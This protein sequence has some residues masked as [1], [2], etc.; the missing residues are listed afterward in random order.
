MS[1]DEF[2]K[3]MENAFERSIM[4]NNGIKKP[5]EDI[6]LYHG[7]RGGIDGDIAPISRVRCD[8]GKGFYLGTNEMQAKGL[9]CDDSAPFYYS[10][11]LHLSEIDPQKVLRLDGEDWLYTV[12]AHRKNCEEFNGLETAKRY[13]DKLTK[14][15][16]VIGSIA[17]DR[18]NE[19][20]TAFGNRSLTDVGLEAC[21]KYID[22]GEQYVLKTE[23]ACGL[24]EILS[25]KRLQGQELTHAQNISRQARAKSVDVVKEAVD[26]YQRQGRYLNELIKELSSKEIKKNAR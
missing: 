18:M 19:A 20:I 8:F 14:Y 23:S 16:V 10:I 7:S 9:V 24:A 6:V 22:Y 5:L 26:K 1:S 21:L 11:K 4:Y 2:N 15:D 12:L 25:E 17:D 3:K 13:L